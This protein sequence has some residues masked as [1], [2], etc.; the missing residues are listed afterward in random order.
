MVVKKIIGD[1]VGSFHIKNQRMYIEIIF[2]SIYT[3]LFT[4]R[5]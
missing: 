3:V 4:R 5:F 1:I 2:E